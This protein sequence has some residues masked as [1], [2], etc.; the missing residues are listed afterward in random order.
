MQYV[1][2]RDYGAVFNGVADDTAA[3]QAAIDAAVRPNSNPNPNDWRAAIVQLPPGDGRI[4]GTLTLPANVWLRG[5]GPA[6][7]YLYND[8][9]GW[10]LALKSGR[11]VQISITDLGIINKYDAGNGIDLTRTGGASILGDT[12]H[13]VENVTVV[14]GRC[15]LNTFGGTED[16]IL[17][18]MAYRQ[19][20]VSG[21]AAVYIAGSDCM[22]ERVTIAQTRNPGLYG[23]AGLRASSSNSRFVNVKIF[24]GDPA[25]PGG[26]KQGAFILI[27]Q[28]NLVTALEVQDYP[29]CAIEDHQGLSTFQGVT[30]DSVK[31]GGV[32]V[33]PGALRPV[34]S[35]LQVYWR[36]G[37]RFMT[38]WALSVPDNSGAII[39]TTLFRVGGIGV[40]KVFSSPDQ[41]GAGNFITANGSRVGS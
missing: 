7:T 40:N 16:R 41:T 26:E 27:G 10:A 14:G 8:T 35:G 4:S 34:Y 25:P 6:S 31:G 9:V 30:I 24:G 2:A 20:P 5:H 1:D 29:G 23:G 21:S 18:F 36:P 3:I 38:P 13:R 39:D 12:A 19:M 15:A 28:R 33:M 22:V 37:G 17:N 32:F 11:E